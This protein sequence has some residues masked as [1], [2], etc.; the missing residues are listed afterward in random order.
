MRALDA[1]LPRELVGIGL[2]EAALGAARAIDVH[3]PSEVVLLGTAG[4]YPGSGLEIGDVVVGGE[5]LLGAASG[6][7]VEGMPRKIASRHCAERTL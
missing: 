2:V 6:D 3:R 1:S 4:A 7:L 5:I